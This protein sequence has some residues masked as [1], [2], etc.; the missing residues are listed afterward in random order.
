MPTSNGFRISLEFG[1]GL[2]REQRKI[3][4]EAARRWQQVIR[5]SSSSNGTVAG[6]GPLVLR[7]TASAPQLDGPGRVLGRA[8]PTYLREWDGLPVQGIMEFDAADLAEMQQAGT[9][10][11]VILHVRRVVYSLDIHARL[12]DWCLVTFRLL[13]FT[14]FP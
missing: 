6:P 2:T 8:G 7:I 11:D 9:L 1:P 10:K 5:G 12:I 14:S 13:L 4:T 3:F